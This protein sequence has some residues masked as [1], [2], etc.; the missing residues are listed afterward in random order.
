[1][2]QQ[3]NGR[4]LR[5]GPGGG[6]PMMRRR[7]LGLLVVLA[8]VSGACIKGD[9]YAD[10]ERPDHHRGPARDARRHGGRGRAL[11]R[12]RRRVP[13]AR[14]RTTASPCPTPRPRPV[15]GWQLDR[16]SMPANADGVHIDPTHWNDLDGFSPGAALLL[17]DPR[18]RPR[19]VRRRR[20]SPTSRRRSTPTR[21]SCCS[22]PHRRA[23]RRTGPSSTPTRGDRRGAHPVRAPRRQ[24]AR[25]PPHRGRASAAW[26]TPPATRWRPPTRSARS[27]T[28]SRPT[29]PRSRPAARPWSGSSPTSTPAG[30]GR[31]DLQLAWDFTVASTDRAVGAACS[32]MRDDAFA[33]LGDGRPG[34]HRHQRHPVGP[35]GHRPRGARHLRGAAVPRRRRRHRQRARARRRRP[36]HPHRHVHRP[37]P[38]HR[39]RLG[40]RGRT[41][42]AAASTATACSAPPARC[43][44]GTATWRRTAT[45]S[46]A[47][48][49]SSAWPRR[50]PATP[51]RIIDD[52]ST[53]H[54][55]ADRL[56]QGHLNTLFL[57]RL[58]IHPDG[59]GRDPAFQDGGTPILTDDARV[60]RH[61]PGRDHGRATTAVAQDWKRGGARRARRATTACCSTA[62]STSTRSGPC[63]IPPTRSPA[64]GPSACSSSRCCGTAARPT[65]TSSTSPTDPYADTPKHQVLLHVAFGDHQVANV[66]TEVEAR[67]LGL[68]VHRPVY[69]DGRTTAVNDVVRD[70][71]PDATRT[72]ARRWWCGTAARR[73]RPIEN[74]PPRDGRDPHGDPR[75]PPRPSTR[76][77]PS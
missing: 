70:R 35:R 33:L 56:Q 3:I 71:R 40:H 69:A 45:S 8:L 12:H 77:S 24:P 18:R 73:S 68:S 74:Q 27:A 28:A 64:T 34:L 30:V 60:L 7:A 36:A 54:T 59:F 65:A 17:P 47:A 57:G 26:S 49:T 14:S 16:E 22:T 6:G 10:E 4:E 9:R 19:R 55:L 13:A 53:F 41:G 21:R 50:T 23:A 11:R 67:T 72:A 48:P 44:G 2:H 52:L 20:R 75:T 61:Q 25:G 46:S 63:S 62:A 15:A 43:R 39:A 38:L 32:H 58:L 5:H 66:A 76:S 1:M 51:S 42:P 31:D 29:C 37:L